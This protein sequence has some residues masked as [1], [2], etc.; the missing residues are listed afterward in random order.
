MIKGKEIKIK[1]LNNWILLGI[2]GECFKI[3]I[4]IIAIRKMYVVHSIL[5]TNLSNVVQY[6]V[7]F[8][9]FYVFYLLDIKMKANLHNISEYFIAI[10]LFIKI[11]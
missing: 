10:Y 1:L 5:I 11:F 4:L 8:D 3:T 7:D 6:N 9:I 2:I